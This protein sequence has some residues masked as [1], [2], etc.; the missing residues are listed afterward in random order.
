MKLFIAIFFLLSGLA[1]GQT[2]FRAVMV[3]S[4]GVLQRPTNFVTANQDVLYGTNQTP[5]L[6]N[7]TNGQVTYTNTNALTFTNQIFVDSI[8]ASN[9]VVLIGASNTA[10][11]Q[12][13]SSG[14]NLM[15]RDLSDARY[16]FSRW[17]S[18]IDLV[19]LDGTTGLIKS[20]S[21]GNGV[22]NPINA[23]GVQIPDSTSAFNLPVDWRISGLVKVVSYWSDRV[24]TNVGAT[25]ATITVQSFPRTSLP[26]DNTTTN[27]QN[28]GTGITNT[29]TANYGGSGDSRYYIVE[30]TV[31]FGT[32]TNISGTNPMQIKTIQI[33]R[34]T[35]DSSTNII[36][37]NGIHVYVP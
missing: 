13:A 35:N 14:A 2:N 4:N 24:Y 12:T 27:T 1:Y 6:F 15:T 20:T 26:I 18:A 33:S 5:L 30:Q 23:Q 31:D 8:T 7:S 19:Y 29:F 10:S 21:S 3:D 25:N 36:M 28:L 37:L 9:D 16:S 32:V 17:Y 11:N 22:G 34:N